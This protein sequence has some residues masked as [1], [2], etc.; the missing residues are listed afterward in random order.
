MTSPT[1]LYRHWDAEGRLLYVG[2]SLSAVQRLAAH[3][4]S[5]RWYPRIKWIEIER[6]PTREA[7][8]E[9]ERIAIR[10]EKPLC[11]LDHNKPHWSTFEPVDPITGHLRKLPLIPK[12]EYPKRYPSKAVRGFIIK[13]AA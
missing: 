13:E 1:D 12:E 11:N 7:A 4:Q 9:A 3:R 2:I 10:D 5:S 8:L 6:H